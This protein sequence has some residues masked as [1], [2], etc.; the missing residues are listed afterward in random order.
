MAQWQSG[1]VQQHVHWNETFHSL[2][3]ATDSA[4]AFEAG[5]YTRL[6][7]EVDGSLIARPYSFVNPP[8]QP[9]LEFYFNTVPDGPLSNRLALL[10]VGNKVEI[11]VPVSGF[12]VLDELP[13]GRD[14]WLFATGSAI[15][16]YLSILGSEQLWQRFERVLLVWGTPFKHRQHYAP[17]LNQFL[18]RYG[19][20]FRW[21]ACLSRESLEDAQDESSISDTAER[22][23]YSRMTVALEDGR[24]EQQLGAQLGAKESQV[25]LCGSPT[26][27]SEM[28]SALKRRGLT[29]NLR[30]SPGQVT[31]ER[32][33]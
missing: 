1:V 32:Y 19:D 15:G 33:W 6:G 7:L 21:L 26:M 18:E 31:V 9:L 25:M 30:R 29:K 20:R 24:L 17:V 2:Q 12:M 14:L 8:T 16:P 22:I 13:P 11:A 4:I 5:Q 28:L 27:V 23:V 10:E 3:I